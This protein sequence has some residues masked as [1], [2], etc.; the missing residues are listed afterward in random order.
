MYDMI[1]NV[2]VCLYDMVYVTCTGV[3]LLFSQEKRIV[4]AEINGNSYSVG[5]YF[6]GRV[7]AELPVQIGLPG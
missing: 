2:C 3:V 5:A 7:M 4:T 1:L 6:I